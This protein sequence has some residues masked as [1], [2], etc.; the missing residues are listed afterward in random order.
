VNPI[1][2]MAGWELPAYRTLTIAA[3]VVAF[4]LAVPT[5]V[6]R[7]ITLRATLAVSLAAAA[8]GL[9]GGRLLAAA[10]AAEPFWGDVG[11]ALEVQFGNMAIFGGLAGATLA[12]VAAARA[13]GVA[14]LRF[15]DAAAPAVGIGIALL[16]V[17]CLLAGCC[18]GRETALPWG[19]TYPLGSFAHLH[20]IESGGSIFGVL[21]GVHPVHP[22]PVF[23]IV[24]AVLL[25]GAAMMLLRRPLRHGTAIATV[26]GG[27]AIVRL[28]IEPLRAPE[29]GGTPAWFDP[30]MFAALAMAAAVWAAWPRLAGRRALRRR[31]ATA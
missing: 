27:Y 18:F 30:A 9:V 24:A 6:R 10:T 5:A 7:G 13:V 1:L 31:V 8:G 17:G 11:T 29:P 25:A 4:G 15:G 2:E 28:L 16:R 20:Q 14:P 19:I 26:V 12:G 3:V 21:Q 22:I 23:E